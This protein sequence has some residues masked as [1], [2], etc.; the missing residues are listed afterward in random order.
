MHEAGYEAQSNTYRLIQSIVFTFGIR[1]HEFEID[2]TRISENRLS[3]IEYQSGP[4]HAQANI[5][6]IW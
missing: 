3:Q 6:I 4:T 1:T 5:T 2:K